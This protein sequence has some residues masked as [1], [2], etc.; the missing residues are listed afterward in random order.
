MRLLSPSPK[1]FG[2]FA[3][4]SAVP[5]AGWEVDLRIAQELERQILEMAKEPQYGKSLMARWYEHFLG[6]RALK[7]AGWVY[8]SSSCS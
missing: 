3:E 2:I 8:K 6:T 5:L 4:R 7:Q 1:P